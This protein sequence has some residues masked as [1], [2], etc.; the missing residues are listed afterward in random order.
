MQYHKSVY[1]HC[2][3]YLRW[4]FTFSLTYYHCVYLFS[5]HILQGC[6]VIGKLISY[7][8]LNSPS[9]TM[10]D[11]THLHPLIASIPNYQSPVLPMMLLVEPLKKR[12]K[13]HFYGSKQTNSLEKVCI[14]ASVIYEEEISFCA[15]D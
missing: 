1:N 10:S 9:N 6:A 12:F 13:Y 11:D 3:L 8:F 5:L 2:N 15:W 7:I 14:A 4:D